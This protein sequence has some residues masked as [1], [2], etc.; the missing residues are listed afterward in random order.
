MAETPQHPSQW[1]CRKCN[2]RLPGVYVPKI[3]P[4]C[5]AYAKQK[6]EEEISSALRCAGCSSVIKT[7]GQ[8][9]C[10]ICCRE[11]KLGQGQV[12]TVV[13]ATSGSVTRPLHEQPGP[14]SLVTAQNRSA[15]HSDIT[16]Q[17]SKATPQQTTLAEHSLQPDSQ[18][19][20]ETQL[21]LSSQSPNSKNSSI[22]HLPE[23]TGVPQA[24]HPSSTG[25]CVI[26]E[27]SEQPPGQKGGGELSADKGNR[28]ALYLN[29]KSSSTPGPAGGD[30]QNGSNT[31]MQK[32]P[33]LH[34]GVVQVSRVTYALAKQDCSHGKVLLLKE[35]SC[36]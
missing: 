17:V 3:C 12:E 5:G 14:P 28:K 32:R 4:E 34:A 2:F 11:Q 1:Q 21:P 31:Q 20:N 27:S 26:Q 16:Q 24:P 36:L 15:T 10:D 8:R 29:A 7:P 18:S 25:Q 30:S 19:K 23:S 35:H 22:P 9:L 13:Q 33:V 6:T